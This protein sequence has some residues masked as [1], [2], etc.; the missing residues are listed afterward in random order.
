MMTFVVELLVVLGLMVLNG[1]FAAAEIAVV[2]V[3]ASRVADLAGQG[4]AGADLARSRTPAESSTRCGRSSSLMTSRR[5]MR[6][7]A[8]TGSHSSR[9]PARPG[10]GASRTTFRPWASLR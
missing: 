7:S 1:V 5:L 8:V 10:R 3:R 4:G 9:E 2:A 6:S